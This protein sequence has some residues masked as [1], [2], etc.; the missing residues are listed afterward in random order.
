MYTYICI[1]IFRDIHRFRSRHDK[2]RLCEDGT[3]HFGKLEL[4]TW[5]GVDDIL[6]EQLGWGGCLKEESEDLKAKFEG[7]FGGNELKLAKHWDSVSFLSSF[8]CSTPSTALSNARV[9]PSS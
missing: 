9:M 2:F 3:L 7:E 1:Y 8:Q 6:E 4:I 5:D